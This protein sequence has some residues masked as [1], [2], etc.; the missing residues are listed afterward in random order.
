[1]SA[2]LTC[3]DG[4]RRC[5]RIHHGS[6]SLVTNCGVNHDAFYSQLVYDFDKS[7]VLFR[8]G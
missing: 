2:V 5:R 8:V 3:D 4:Q 7:T 1:M 6:A